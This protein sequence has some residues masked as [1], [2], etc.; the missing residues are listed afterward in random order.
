MKTIDEKVKEILKKERKKIFKS[1]KELL[2][3]IKELEQFQLIITES[4]YQ[5][6]MKDT[7]GKNISFNTPYK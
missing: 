2:K 4:E 3:Q 7:I 5:I 6:P 1:E